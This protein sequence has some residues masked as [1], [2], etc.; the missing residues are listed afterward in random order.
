MDMF[1]SDALYSCVCVSV[2]VCVWCCVVLCGA[3][4][5]H[6]QHWYKCLEAVDLITAACVPSGLHYVCGDVDRV[7]LQKLHCELH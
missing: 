3:V 4:R 1:I 7:R 5:P 6:G 2:H